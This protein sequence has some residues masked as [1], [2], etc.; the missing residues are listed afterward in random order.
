MY[1]FSVSTNDDN[2]PSILAT[3]NKIER[4]HTS[5]IYYRLIINKVSVRSWLISQSVRSKRNI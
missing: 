1:V 5:S 2:I 4:L 3:N